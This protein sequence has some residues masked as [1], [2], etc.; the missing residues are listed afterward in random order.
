MTE[1]P[2]SGRESDSRGYEAGMAAS[3]VNAWFVREVLPLEAALR[4]YL[5]TGW[6]NDSDVSDMCQDIFVRTLEA[7]R[8]E[9]PHA[10]RPFVFSIARN[11]LLNRLHRN[12]IVSID[13]VADMESFGLA[14]DEPLPDRSLS[15]RQ[16]WKR[17]QSA[18][19]QLPE[20]W[21]DAVVM[22]KIEGLPR[23]EIAQ[24]MGLAERTV[25]Q[26]LASGIAALTDFFNSDTPEP[27]GAP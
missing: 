27:N 20:R 2:E 8:T 5:R 25:A 7:A 10:A 1:T 16:D 6:R 4:R 13:A 9:I 18:L 22:R 14:S 21:R 23:K 19:S 3:E 11:H 15:A 17:L 24:R 26:H 12:Q